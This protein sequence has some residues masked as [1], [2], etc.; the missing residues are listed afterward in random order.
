LRWPESLAPGWFAGLRWRISQGL[1]RFDAQVLRAPAAPAGDGLRYDRL[2]ATQQSLWRALQAWAWQDVGDGRVPLWRP[3]QRAAVPQPL[4]VAVMVCD[5]LV[6]SAAWVEAFCCDIDG[7][8]RLLALPQARA[9]VVWRL[10][11]KLSELAWWRGG[12]AHRPWDAGFLRADATA[13]EQRPG[14]RPR[15]PTFMVAMAMDAPAL[16]ACLQQLQ[17]GAQAWDQAVRLLVLVS[18]PLLEPAAGQVLQLRD[19]AAP[20]AAGRFRS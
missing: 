16:Q 5:D 7:T 9:R 15:R 4:A 14:F 3:W 13:S 19:S 10:R 1:A 12:A 11:I 18:S 6:L 2:T 8:D 20:A 17:S